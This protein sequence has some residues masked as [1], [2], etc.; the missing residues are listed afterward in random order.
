MDAKNINVNLTIT[1]C[2]FQ[3]PKIVFI[4]NDYS[5]DVEHSIS[6]DLGRT[7]GSPGGRPLISRRLSEMGL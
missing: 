6:M 5:G 7:W 4:M 1:F 3:L 2:Q